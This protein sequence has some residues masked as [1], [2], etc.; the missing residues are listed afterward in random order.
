MSEAGGLPAVI[1]VAGA[2]TM[3]TG[4]AQ[5]AATAGI[6]T[7]LFDPLPG[8]AERGA[9]RVL[10]GLE[11][12]KARGKLSADDLRAAWERIEAVDSIAGLASCELVI[13]A[14]PEEPELKQ[15]LYE[16]LAAT[17]TADC[18][19][20]SNTSS[21]PITALAAGVPGPERVVGMHFFNPAPVMKLVEV[22]A[23]VNTGPR[24]LA[25][26]RATGTAMGRRVIDAT[27][28]PGFLVNRCGRPFGLEALRCVTE[29]LAEPHVVDRIARLGGRFRMGP[30][31]LQDLVGIDTGFAV[32]ESFFELSFGEPRWRPSPLSARMVA[33]GRHGRKTGRGWYAYDDAGAI[34]REPDP[35]APEAGDVPAGGMVVIAGDL[36]IADD[37]RV[38]AVEAGWD[39]REPGDAAGEVP[40]LI[41]DCGG[42]PGDDPLQGGPVVLLCAEGSL[43][44]LDGGGGAAGFHALPPLATGGLVELT[45][46]TGTSA[47]S[48]ERAERFF[49]SL[50]LHTAWVGDAPGLVLGRIVCQLVNEAAFAVGEGVGSADDVDAGMVLGLNHP[51]G[52][53]AWGDEI[54]LDHV[55][56][57]LDALQAERGDPAY[58]P[59]P[60]LRELVLTGRLG[61]QTGHGFHEHAGV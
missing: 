59:A 55:L 4:I 58:R 56:T 16:Q 30:F 40:D 60:L 32:S 31:E 15:A 54:G 46:T 25:I 37:L 26:A 7:L 28:G 3:G 47:H 11:G 13:E 9:S 24:A 53:L 41:V 20:A 1:G 5:L 6:R 50:G 23:G 44:A 18:V 29:G 14:A 42:A 12:A 36:Q 19:L 45:R 61:V 33:S 2:G 10:E 39:V 17:V 22:I 35:P 52:P 34:V 48:A 51:R 43:A 38:L 21:I 8:A 49:G 57:V 27:D